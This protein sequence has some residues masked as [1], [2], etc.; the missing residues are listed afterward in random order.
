MSTISLP[1]SSDA[2][3]AGDELEFKQ[4]NREAHYAFKWHDANSGEMTL[5]SDSGKDRRPVTHRFT[6]LDG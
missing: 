4:R 2:V 1:I 5:R 6:R 3:A